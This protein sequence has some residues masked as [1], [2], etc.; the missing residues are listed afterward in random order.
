MQKVA[1]YD[2]ENGCF[3]SQNYKKIKLVVRDYHWSR[4]FNLY[5]LSEESEPDF[6]M[7]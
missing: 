5:T 7:K 1:S 4:P 3:P 6:L 2:I